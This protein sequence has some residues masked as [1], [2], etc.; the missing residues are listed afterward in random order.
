MSKSHGDIKG[1]LKHILR[2]FFARHKFGSTLAV[3]NRQAQTAIP[4]IV[5]ED[6]SHV[7]TQNPPFNFGPP[8]PALLSPT[9]ELNV[10]R[11]PS[12]YPRNGNISQ[13]GVV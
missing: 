13:Y 12:L 3:I 1:S 2:Q 5:C 11:K 4:T 10:G 7:M 9:Y 8:I 6:S